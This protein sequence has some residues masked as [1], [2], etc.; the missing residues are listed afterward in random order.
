[1]LLLE[2]SKCW[3]ILNDLFKDPYQFKIGQFKN[4]V[5]ADFYVKV[6]S[7]KIYVQKFLK[8]FL[9]NK[10]SLLLYRLPNMALVQFCTQIVSFRTHQIRIL[11][12]F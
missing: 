8:D 3:K 10:K 4:F 9:L 5:P 12:Y 1:M 6:T 11:F 2:G 7:F